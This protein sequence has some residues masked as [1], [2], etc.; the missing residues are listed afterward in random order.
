MEKKIERNALAEEMELALRDTFVAR[1]VRNE[2]ELT[3]AFANGQT[4]CVT[5]SEK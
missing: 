3:V 1:I 2:N 5:V 4:F